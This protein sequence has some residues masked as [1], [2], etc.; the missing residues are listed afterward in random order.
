MLLRAKAGIGIRLWVN[1]E[2]MI[3]F[4][5]LTQNVFVNANAMASVER[6]FQ[7]ND[8]VIEKDL[9]IYEFNKVTRNI[10]QNNKHTIL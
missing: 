9:I 2:N 1:A 6:L 3:S 10:K 4:L 8:D 5:L 7:L